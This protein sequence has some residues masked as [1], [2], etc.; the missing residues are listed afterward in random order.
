MIFIKFNDLIIKNMKIKIN[1]NKLIVK[2][3]YRKKNARKNGNQSLS[4]FSKQLKYI[5]FIR[6][7]LFPS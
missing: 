1:S 7:S 3:I 4:K 5:F 6:Y 2:G